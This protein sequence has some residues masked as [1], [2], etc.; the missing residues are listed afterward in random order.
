MSTV[1][2]GSTGPTGPDA[3]SRSLA[4][5]LRIS[6]GALRLVMVVVLALFL[7]S[8][9]FKVKEGEVAVRLHFGALHKA[10][11]GAVFEPGGPYFAWPEP[12]DCVVRVPVMTQQLAIGKAFWFH[13]DEGDALK[14]IEQ[15]PVPSGGLAPERDGSALTAD[16]NVL[17]G[18]WVIS[19][20]ATAEGA[21][22]FIRN[23]SASSDR[24]KMLEEAER[25]VRCAAE[26]ALV[27]AVAQSRADDVVT[28]NVDWDAAAGARLQQTL[29]RMHT[30]I[31]IAKV[32]LAQCTPPLAVRSAFQ[33]VTQAQEEKTRAIVDA[34]ISRAKLL[35]ETAG[36]AHPI[37]LAALA[38]YEAALRR[39]DAAAAGRWERALMSFL[40]GQPADACFG[41][42]VEA[43]GDAA[44]RRNLAAALLTP[45]KVS[46]RVHELV[47]KARGESEGAVQ[48]VRGEL[49][50]FQGLLQQHQQ[51]PRVVR[52]RLLLSALQEIFAGDVERFY[53]PRG[54][55]EVYLELSRDPGIRQRQEREAYERRRR[56]A[57]E[58]KGQ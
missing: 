37:A 54:Q 53:L 22:D 19:W 15:L 7:A 50:R 10:E 48:S 6:F 42:V 38:Q 26:Q 29:D 11:D 32:A 3:A 57:G 35:G 5:A 39:G 45:Q 25:I 36:Q 12:V 40:D 58:K 9:S 17:H 16:Q 24:K 43:E 55:K 33:A 52:D 23:V 51:N 21:R 18:K 28:G 27:Q 13:Q 47:Q 56:E 8:G 49:E 31:R 44:Q 20:Q 1:S 4:D 2:T 30:G 14:P 46:G 34:E 41:P